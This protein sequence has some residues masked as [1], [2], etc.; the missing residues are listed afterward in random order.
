MYRQ[1]AVIFVTVVVLPSMLQAAEV[2]DHLKPQVEKLKKLLEQEQGILETRLAD[3]QSK[4]KTARRDERRHLMQQIDTTKKEINA[5]KGGALPDNPL[6]CHGL[7]VGKI[8]VVESHL[9]VVSVLGPEKMH[10]IPFHY[11]GSDKEREGGTLIIYG[12]PTK[13]VVDGQTLVRLGLVEVT[14][15]ERYTTVVGGAKTVFKITWY[16]AAALK[17]Y[18]EKQAATVDRGDADRARP[19][20]TWTDASDTFS[21]KASFAGS[22]L[23]KVKLRK[24]DGSIIEVEFDKLSAADQEYI[25]SLR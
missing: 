17:P 6:D 8:G 9:E 7:A 12:Y 3:L 11:V 1:L 18:L 15:T 25:R 22:A 10:V 2:P 21:V 5:I 20:R 14:G 4:L 23:G 19:T 13:G 16:D 24:E